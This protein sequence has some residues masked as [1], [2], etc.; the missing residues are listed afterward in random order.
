M[1]KYNNPKAFRYLLF[2]HGQMIDKLNRH[3]KYVSR[4]EQFQLLNNTSIFMNNKEGELAYDT[5]IV[6]CF[7]YENHHFLE[8]N[9]IKGPSNKRN[10][11]INWSCYGYFYM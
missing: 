9:I 8:E 6:K 2:A 3:K 4:I 7:N 10:T 11:V 1:D 5:H